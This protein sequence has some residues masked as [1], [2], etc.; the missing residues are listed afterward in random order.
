MDALKG[1]RNFDMTNV[2]AL[3]RG[4]QQGPNALAW[5]CAESI[6]HSRLDMGVNR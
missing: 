6:R 3:P 4:R 1:G 2:Q 5:E